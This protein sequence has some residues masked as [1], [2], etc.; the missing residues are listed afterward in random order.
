MELSDMMLEGLKGM[1]TLH[2]ILFMAIGMVIGMI[3]GCIPGLTGGIA[4]ALCLPF[5]FY[6]DVLPSMALLIGIYTGSE[7]G[8]SIP[9]ILV[10]TPGTPQA[11]MTVFD[12]FPLAKKG[13]A[14][15]ALKMALYASSCGNF[16]A[17][18][19]T[20]FLLV[21]LSKFALM[22]GPAE[23]FSVIL[24]SIILIATIGSSG[25]WIKGLM[26]TMIGLFFSFIGTDPITGVPRFVFSYQLL[27]GIEL[28]PVLM[29]LFVGS[30]LLTTVNVHS[31]KLEF[32]T[33]KNSDKRFTKA[34]LKTCAPL[35]V[36]GSFI[37]AII[38]ALPGLN[39][40]ISATLNYTFAKRI[41]KHPEQFGTGI[42]E[43]VCAPECANNATAGPTL[44]PLLTMGIP[45]SGT[46][47]IFMGALMIQGVQVGP[48]IFRDY[49]YVVY[50]IFFAILICTILMVIIGRV[51]LGGAQYIALIPAEILNPI[52]IF[53]CIAGAFAGNSSIFDV[54]MFILFMLV[55][56]L[57]HLVKIPVLPLLISYLL[58]GMLEANFRRAL[59][60]SDGGMSIFFTHK[61]SCVF[62]IITLVILV[63]AIF[64]PQIKKI[65]HRKERNKVNVA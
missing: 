2:A 58:G 19:C 42:I 55:G 22:M 60:L 53:T 24:F 30:G 57:I 14:G 26:G 15:R 3:F 5:T 7:F 44:A 27:G 54:Y 18:F 61:I 8:G 12:G 21:G 33:Y 28:V 39:A 43:G 64:E 13:E 16:F 65:M 32:Q 9:A 41:S 38:G 51:I 63:Y 29:G 17:S 36:S 34:E 47:A 1:L 23:L 49:G 31:K 6:M 40:A 46:A 25:S 45:G 37:G 50:G 11:S 56:Y 52:I 62:I 35:I 20:I 10:G 4:I 48:T 59:V